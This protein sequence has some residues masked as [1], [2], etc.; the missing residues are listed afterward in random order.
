MATSQD[1]WAGLIRDWHQGLDA[2]R[3][4]KL[5]EVIAHAAEGVDGPNPKE[6]LNGVMC[7]ALIAAQAE[8]ASEAARGWSEYG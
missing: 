2:R 7:C 3:Q 1:S 5:Q 4:R 8:S 6:Q